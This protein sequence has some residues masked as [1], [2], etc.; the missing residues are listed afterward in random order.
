MPRDS[1]GRFVSSARSSS[2]PAARIDNNLLSES[3][4][5]QNSSNQNFEGIT[6]E[7]LNNITAQITS[8]V[9]NNLRRELTSDN[10]RTVNSDNP[11]NNSGTVNQSD[12]TNNFNEETL[13][14]Q[15]T[16]GNN[17]IRNHIASSM[18]IKSLS[19]D[20]PIY[21]GKGNAQTLF[22][23][24][25]NVDLY[26]K[27]I[28]A[29]E[30]LKLDFVVRHL[31]DSARSWWRQQAAKHENPIKNWENLKDALRVRFI[32]QELSSKLLVKLVQLTQSNKSVD[33]YAE[34]F[35]KIS[36]QLPQVQEE[37]LITF[38]VNGLNSE[39]K[40]LVKTNPKNLK[41]FDTVLLAAIRQEELHIGNTLPQANFISE[42]SYNNNKNDLKILR[43]NQT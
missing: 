25:E 40:K 38:F 20:I 14:H 15:E 5:L 41:S 33:V 12:L 31:G 30:S 17:D 32:S 21:N 28:N 24:I 35:Q 11:E 8:N 4:N 26:M 36:C 18:I 19:S 43:E 10:T 39:I 23:F 22:T 13:N 34:Q 9:L 37:D 16:V 29:S 3:E 7:I 6:P 2:V 42:S 27:H 1:N